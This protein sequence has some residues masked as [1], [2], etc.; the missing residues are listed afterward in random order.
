LRRAAEQKVES[1]WIR[2]NPEEAASWILENKENQSHAVST[3]INNW[4]WNQ[5]EKLYDWVQ[6]RTDPKLK[7]DAN[8]N[9]IRR[10]SYNNTDM[11]KKALENIESEDLRKKAVTQLYRSLQYR[12]QKAASEFLKGRD[13]VSDL[14][15]E[16]LISSK[17]YRHK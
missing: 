4:N 6:K 2:S 1:A 11:A 8:Y 3:I 14:E 15:K 5:G 9:L 13:E 10:Y 12:D 17:S 16:K 7:D